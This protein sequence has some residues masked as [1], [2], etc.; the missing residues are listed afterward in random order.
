MRGAAGRRGAVAT[1]ES[2]IGAVPR[3]AV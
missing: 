3:V 1:V 2:A